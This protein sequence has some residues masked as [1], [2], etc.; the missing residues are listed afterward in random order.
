MLEE[1]DWSVT[2]DGESLAGY[3]ISKTDDGRGSQEAKMDRPG[4]F[5]SLYHVRLTDRDSQDTDPSPPRSSQPVHQNMRPMPLVRLRRSRIMVRPPASFLRGQEV[6]RLLPTRPNEKKSQNGMV[7]DAEG[8]DLT[9][10][11]YVTRMMAKW[12]CTSSNPCPRFWWD[13]PR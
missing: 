2:G 8:F 13:A 11:E 10:A 1:C 6:Q 3:T 7:C 9:H 12:E 5:R 4:I